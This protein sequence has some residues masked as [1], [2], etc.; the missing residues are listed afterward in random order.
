MA[1]IF[2]SNIVPDRKE[3]WNNAFLSQRIWMLNYG[4][5]GHHRHIP[6]LRYGLKGTMLCLITVELYT[7]FPH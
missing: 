1:F 3:Y 4:A 7:L 2:I 6:K 5:V